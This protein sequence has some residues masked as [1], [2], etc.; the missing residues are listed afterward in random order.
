MMKTSVIHAT[1]KPIASIGGAAVQR[2][3]RRAKAKNAAIHRRGRVRKQEGGRVGF[4]PTEKKAAAIRRARP[5]AAD[6]AVAREKF[7]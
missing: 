7:S 4:P 5:V 6:M 2:I 3:V 1:Q